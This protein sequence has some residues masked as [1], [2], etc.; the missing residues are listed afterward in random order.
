MI[1]HIFFD[2]DNTLWDHRKN[3][4]LTLK[5]IFNDE[6]LS[7]R[8]GLNF[9]DFHREYF[10]IN[11][12]LWAQIRDG[13]IDKEYLRKHRFYDS[14]LFFKIDDE[15]LAERIENNFL[16]QILRYNELVPGAGPLL[17]YLK[18]KNY[19]LHILSNGFQEVTYRK[20]LLSDI[21][22]YFENI[23]SADDIDVRK[24]Q[25]E[26]FQY[27][28]QKANATKEESI[29]IGDDWTADVEGALSFGMDAIFFDV[30]EDGF[31]AGTVKTIKKL[32]EIE[33]WL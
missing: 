1:Q 5:D 21:D 30:F 16:D 12:N 3:A 17:D 24:P 29:M 9:E 25:P 22:R 32:E 26:I 11:E 8:F 15:A 7:E 27:A 13:K 33:Q 20:T 14:L 31:G 19:H 28:L 10:T 23:I 6:E 4:Y 18:N 2:L